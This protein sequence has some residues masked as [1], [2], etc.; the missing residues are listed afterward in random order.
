MD[1]HRRDDYQPVLPYATLLPNGKVLVVGGDANNSPYYLSSAEVYDPATGTWTA[2][3]SM[4][5]AHVYHTAT[6]LPDGKV[7]VAG[8]VGI[9]GFNSIAELYDPATGTWRAGGTMKRSRWYH[10]A[11]LLTNGMVLVAGGD[12]GVLPSAELYNPITE[13]WADTGLMT[14]NRES[15]TATLLP[16]GQVLVAGGAAPDSVHGGLLSLASAELFDPTTGDW[17]ATTNNLKIPRANQTATLL[18]N[19][20]V[21]LA[22]GFRDG[23]GQLSS[24]EVYDPI[25]GAW[26]A[27][28]NA[29]NPAR[30]GHTATLLPGGRILVA[31]GMGS[32][33][34]TNSTEVYDSTSKTNTET[35]SLNIARYNPTVTLLP[36]G[37]VLVAG[38][39]DASAELYDPVS[40]AWTVTGSMN[41][42][43]QEGH[44]ATLLSNGKVLVVGGW[45]SANYYL[46]TADLYDPS[47]GTW[48]AT[49]SLNAKRSYHTATL[50][51]NGKVLIAGG[52]NDTNNYISSTELFDPVTGIWMLTGQLNNAR[53]FHTATLLPNGKVL[54]AGGAGG[55]GKTS[56]LYDPAMGIWT[57]TGSMNTER[58]GHTATL[59]PNGRVL[60][61]AGY[62]NNF[63][64]LTNSELYDPGTGMWTTNGGLT[65]QRAYHTATLL[66]NRKVL[67]AGGE[68]WVPHHFVYT[69]NEELYDP[70]TGIWTTDGWLKYARFHHSATLLPNGKVLFVGGG[71][72]S[73]WLTNTELHDIGLGYANSWQP[74]VAAITSPLNLGTSLVVTG[75]Q[76]RGVSEGSSGNSQDSSA[77]YPLVQLRRLDN[78][79]TVFLL[80]TNW[81]TNSFTSLPVWNFPAGYAL[82]TVFVNGIQSTSSVVNI[83]VPVPT[84]ANLAGATKLTNGFRFAFT[85]NVGALF[86]VLT[87]TNLA[88]PLS[89]WTALGGV[90]EISPGQFQFTDPQATNGGWRFYRAFVP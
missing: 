34:V 36:N 77:D 59:L 85:N 43:R 47:N 67:I 9:S 62:H 25:N 31:G 3:G 58:W 71:G 84:A 8:G 21:L 29:L 82:A 49:G 18:P 83:S 20:Q 16:N 63:V 40:G 70:A 87:T 37:K 22:G 66:S 79:Q 23:P 88:L 44:T 46:S 35:G 72:T 65:I 53:A 17:T 81:S 24:T 50:L 54:V 10:T 64:F 5:G 76:F 51:P 27:S 1:E 33:G 12:S 42:E 28:T 38:G 74:Q 13:A 26:I 80:T 56:E 30:W 75:S 48:S 19:G 52:F 78:E 14:T 45:N 41:T 7:L 6:L 15:H 11:T 39:V 2:T 69:G 55:L 68:L 60:V 90:M 61:V 86:G 89:Q 32:S 57:P 4:I 73:G